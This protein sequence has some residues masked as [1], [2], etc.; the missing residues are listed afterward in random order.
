MQASAV[1]GTPLGLLD[2]FSTPS[3][4]QCIRTP[5]TAYKIS[6]TFSLGCCGYV[7]CRFKL[8]AFQ[9]VAPGKVVRDGSSDC[10]G[11]FI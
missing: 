11:G 2:S 7:H 3:I 5:S 10:G 9:L 1:K 8:L 4:P 6:S